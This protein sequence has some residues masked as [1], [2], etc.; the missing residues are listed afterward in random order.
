MRILFL[1]ALIATTPLGTVV[2]VYAAAPQ[3]PVSDAERTRIESVIVDLLAREPEIVIGAIQEFQRRQRLAQIRPK[4]AQ[5]RDYL[6]TDTAQP[7]L[8]NPDGDVTVVEFFDYRC[9]FC[10]RHFPLVMQLLEE[11]GNIRF[12][13]RQ[14]P[15]LDRPGQPEVSRQAARAAIAAHEQGKFLDFHTAL[16]GHAGP[17]SE[18]DIYTVAEQVGLNLTQLSRDMKSGLTDKIIDNTISIGRDIGFSGTPSYIIGDDVI[19]GAEGLDAL[20]ARVQAARAAGR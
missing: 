12:L 3:T 13:P 7:V 14:F 15:L 19:L 9:G 1:L 18:D 20:R 2:Q 16:M 6:E 11:D 8:G 5:Y 4:L 17:L 10:K